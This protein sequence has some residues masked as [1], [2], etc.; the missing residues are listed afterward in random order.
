M[1]GDNAY[2]S[3]M[4]K[5]RFS[6]RLQFPVPIGRKFCCPATILYPLI[7]PCTTSVHPVQELP[8]RGELSTLR[9]HT[10]RWLGP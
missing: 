1:V 6:K 10:P 2:T 9:S 4:G 7:E 8:I 5:S 3:T